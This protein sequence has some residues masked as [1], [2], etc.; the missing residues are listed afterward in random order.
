MSPVVDIIIVTI[1]PTVIVVLKLVP[2]N[3]RF[4]VFGVCYLWVIPSIILHKITTQQLG[5]QM[6][7]TNGEMLVY[8]V[9]GILSAIGAFALKQSQYLHLRVEKILSQKVYFFISLPVQQFVYFGYMVPMVNQITTNY[10]EKVVMIGALFGSMHLPWASWRLFIATTLVGI[11]WAIAY[12]LYPNL[13][14]S[15]M[16]H[17]ISAAIVFQHKKQTSIDRKERN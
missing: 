7:V 6:H 1:I 3:K 4:V 11:L 13:A 10:I 12:V 14:I 9:V 16:I 5:F 17:A 15:L 8:G 2:S